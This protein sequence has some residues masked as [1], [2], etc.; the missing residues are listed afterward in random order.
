LKLLLN[1]VPK[2]NALA[3]SKCSRRCHFCSIV[4]ACTLLFVSCGGKSENTEGPIFRLVPSAE[5][6][7]TFNNQLSQSPD[8]NIL[9]YPYFYNGGG[10]AAGDIN[11]DGLIDLY[12]TANQSPNKLYLNKGNLA[13]ED[14][15][16][17]AGVSGTGTWATGVTMVDI[18]AD[19]YL[20]IYVCRVG[21]YKDAQ[22]KNEL[23]VNNGDNSFTESA[24][25]YGLDFEGFSTQAAFFDY[26]RDG[27]L[28]MYLLNHSI[29][30]PESFAFAQARLEPNEKGDRLYQNQKAEGKKGFL[31]VTE[32]SGIYS[33]VLGF[34]LGVSTGDLNN[35]GWPDIYVSNDFT[36]NDYLY[37]NNQDG[38]F[39]EQLESRI[40]HTSRYSMGNVLGDMNNDGHQE[41]VTTDMLPADP[42]I[43]KRSLGEDKSEVY[44]IKLTYGYNN[45]YVRNT[46]QKN[47][48]NGQFSDLSLLANSYATDWSWSPLIFDMNNDGFQ[49]LHITNGI[50]KR[51]N[52]LDFINYA[53]LS[54]GNSQDEN[55]TE[56]INTLPTL[57]TPNYTGSGKGDFQLTNKTK[58]WG[59][60]Q[61]SYSNGSTYA[62]LDNDGDL[63]LIVNNLEQ[64]AFIYQ[65][66]SPATST[67]LTIRLKGKG[68]NK[69]AIGAKVK[70]VLEGME[71]Y[72]ENFLTRGFESSVAPELYFGLG[73]AQQIKTIEITWPNGSQQIINDVSV[74]QILEIVENETAFSPEK[75]AKET[76]NTFQLLATNIDFTH[77]EDE[78]TDIG[79][80]YLNPR[81]FNHEGPALATADVDGNGLEDV[82]FGGAKGQSA[83]LW[84][85]KTEGMF[86]KAESRFFDLLSIAE[87]VSATFFDA[88]RDG[89][90]DLYVTS[91]GNEQSETM[92]YS[93]DKLYINQGNGLFQFSPQALNK[94]NSQGKT[95]AVADVDG[96]GDLD[97]FVGSNVVSGA[98]GKNPE[99][100]LLI[101]NGQGF[102]QNQFQN[103]FNIE[104]PIGMI[105]DSE[106]FDY[107]NDG[108]QD[109]VVVGEWMPITIF[110]NNGVGKFE[111]A[112]VKAFE[113]TNGWYYSLAL[114]D[115]DSN[116]QIDL[117]VGNLGLNTKLKAS[118]KE[119]VSLYAADF[120]NNGQIDPIIFHYVEGVESPFATRDDLTKQI[121]AIK[122]KHTSYLDYS[123]IEGPADILGVDYE[124]KSA[125]KKAYT[126]SSK[127][128]LNLG[129]GKFEAIDLPVEAQYSPI[130]D[131][132]AE[133]YNGDGKL[134]LLLFGN[135]YTFRNDYGRADAKP[136]TLLFGKG[137][138]NFLATDDAFLNT[139]STWGQY[140]QA[141][142]MVIGRQKGIVAVRNNDQP[143]FL[144]YE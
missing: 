1:L 134:D 97:V 30:N 70:V 140:R 55:E 112:E 22:G 59:L 36:E 94:V 24:G 144:I 45:Q 63:E 51:P 130:M 40:Q 124:T 66:T 136:I 19:G 139:K 21:N 58:I 53:S 119:P 56:L 116:G 37:I 50:F 28:D 117:V 133:D 8:F 138:G 93:Y 65:N 95:V 20:D 6:G 73:V 81:I 33:S 105:N 64:E 96:D 16:E 15:S 120:D 60:D 5:T 129:K 128:F 2:D 92:I 41:I 76:A 111:K 7:I 13:F 42:Q 122:K 102:F 35:D 75:P 31:D 69:F 74:N 12:F 61:P 86:E 44:K 125:T 29:K 72:R 115:L 9:E 141:K 14:I 113:N 84:L 118:L 104:A 39:T 46:L 62:D 85:Q 103:R 27:D 126:M 114:A 132:V 108:D 101:N 106:W 67:Y 4:L 135:N 80:E 18:N 109:L 100:F 99:Q 79:R 57:K 11:N 10:V 107:D 77:Q 131:L 23:F 98:Y 127:V 110:E 68:E 78:F 48:G 143:I 87:D 54:A 83:E 17:T 34:G 26:D 3:K 82:F 142:P 43:W 90:L 123:K 91:A 121:A 49:D 38:S 25:E 89:D 52:D 32:S 88:D 47:L 71:L 137:D